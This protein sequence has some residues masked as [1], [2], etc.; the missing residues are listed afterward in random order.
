M[1]IIMK[2]KMNLKLVTSYYFLHLRLSNT[3]RSVLSLVM[4]DLAN[5]DALI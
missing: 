1:E 5:P 4:H 2:N 3:F